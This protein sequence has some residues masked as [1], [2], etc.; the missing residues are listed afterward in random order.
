MDVP[1]EV[2]GA[3]QRDSCRVGEGRPGSSTPPV[4][5]LKTVVVVA[6]N[7]VRY[8]PGSCEWRCDGGA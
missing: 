8:R 5:D 7:N 2:S 3:V 1:V 6:E 4:R